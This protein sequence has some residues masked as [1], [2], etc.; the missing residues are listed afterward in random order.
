MYE[1]KTHS[2]QTPCLP[3]S[4]NPV[5]QLRAV[6]TWFGPERRASPR[7][8]QHLLSSILDEVD[9]GLFLVDARHQVLYAN[10]AAL[11]QMQSMGALIVEQNE[12]RAPSRLDANT[13]NAAIK[14]AVAKCLRRMV[15]LGS[16]ADRV[17]VAVVPLPLASIQADARVLIVLSRHQICE[18]LSAQGFARDHGLTGAEGQVLQALSE[19]LQ[20]SA[21]ANAHGVALSTVRTQ[22]SSIRL[23]TCTT[24]IGELIQRIAKLPPIASALR[25]HLRL[26]ATVS[27]R[28][29]L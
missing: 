19:G 17:T 29:G 18:A 1:E 3:A 16:A 23:K 9:Y 21:I 2:T 12:L 6:R 15:T 28:T 20:P 5:P 10:R 24:S 25:G 27:V 11:V 26:G 4:M 7:V 13:F 14:D 8:A 22:I